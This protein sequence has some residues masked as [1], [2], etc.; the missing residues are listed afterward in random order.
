LLVA[1]A[2]ACALLWS[3]EAS[4][5]VKV[6]PSRMVAG[7]TD[8]LIAFVAPNERDNARTVKLEVF[9]PRQPLL[10][11]LTSPIPGWT[12]RT[13]NTTLAKPLRTDDGTIDRVVSSITWTS[14]GRGT[15]PGQY[16]S[17][18]ISVGTMPNHAGTL[19]FKALQTYSSGEVVRWIQVPSSLSPHPDSPAPT[20]TLTK[21]EGTSAQSTSSSGS[22]VGVAALVCSLLA[23]LGV[24]FLLI[25]R[26]SDSASDARP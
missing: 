14:T 17:F 19:V 23:L 6:R 16:Q 21:A 12:S 3:S 2:L 22:A 4:A 5:H 10:G 20:I 9:F 24:A 1:V 26:R 15:L 7:T 13:S 11:V 25:A 8:A 18:P